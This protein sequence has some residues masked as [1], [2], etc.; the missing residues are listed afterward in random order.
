ME[1][2]RLADEQGQPNDQA[3]AAENL[4]AAVAAAYTAIREELEADH[5]QA[6]QLGNHQLVAE[7]RVLQ[8]L[9]ESAGRPT[10]AE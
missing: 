4:L 5:R 9:L 8:H 1:R 7:I 3:T 10:A 2:V 6:E